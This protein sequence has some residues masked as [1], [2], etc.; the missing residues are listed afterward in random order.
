MFESLINPK[1]AERKPIE[2]LGIGFFYAFKF[3]GNTFKL[4]QS[5]QIIFILLSTQKLVV[6][7][8]HLG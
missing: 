8:F 2:M 6:L 4:F 5:L 3:F 7:S 1:K